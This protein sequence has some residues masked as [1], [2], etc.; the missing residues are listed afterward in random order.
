MHT[1]SPI[2]RNMTTMGNW[3]YYDALRSEKRGPKLEA[4][5]LEK[6]KELYTKERR[7]WWKV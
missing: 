3:N 2:T 1:L 4:T 5:H 6:A 7:S